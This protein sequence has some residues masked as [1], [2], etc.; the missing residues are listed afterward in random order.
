MSIFGGLV[1]QAT[2]G[3]QMLITN[4]IAN[5]HKKMFFRR[6]LLLLGLTVIHFRTS[7]LCLVCTM[8]VLSNRSAARQMQNISSAKNNFHM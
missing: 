1:F 6:F 8:E 7:K 2:F 4:T 5:A 3:V